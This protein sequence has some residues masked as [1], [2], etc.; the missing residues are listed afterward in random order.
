MDDKQKTEACV[1]KACDLLRAELALARERERESEERF[2]TLL[3]QTIDG[4][5]RRDLKIDR[6]D[7]LSPA[8]EKM[9]GF[10]A[11]EFGRLSRAELALLVHPDDRGVIER[12]V[13]ELEGSRG[14]GEVNGLFE[15]RLRR[16]DGVYRWLSDSGVMVFGPD[17]EPRY[18]A[19]VARDITESKE[20]EA[21]RIVSLRQTEEA[22]V[23]LRES[24]ERL[25]F[26]GDNLPG[27]LLYQFDC[28]VGG[29]ERQF[30]YISR[31]VEKIHGMSVAEAMASPF[32][33]Y[34]QLHEEDC[35]SFAEME[36]SAIEN[37][38]MIRAETRIILPSG[39]TKWI[40]ITSVPR[41]ASNGHVIWDGFEIDL[42]DRKRL[43]DEL[44][45][46]SQELETAVADRTERLRRLASELALAE[47]RERRHLSDFLHDDLQQVLVAAMYGAE[48]VL[49]D[50]PEGAG[51]ERA[52]KLLG[53]VMEAVG[54]VRSFSSGLT[55][56][57]LYVV[58]LVSALRELAEQMQAR[59]GLRVDF[60]VGDMPDIADEAVRLQLFLAV[61]ELLF[62]ATKHSGVDAVS[63]LGRYSDGR[64]ELMVSDAGKGFD[65]V[66]VLG[67]S[68]GRGY[69]LFSVRERIGDLG[70][71][72][73]VE[74]SPGG[75]TRVTIAMPVQGV[76][77]MEP[78][79]VRRTV[80]PGLGGGEDGKKRAR[81]LV[82]DDHDLV[83]DGVVNVLS[84]DRHLE[85]VGEAKNGREAVELART[86]RPDVIVMDIRM[87]EM[88][89]IEATRLILSELPGVIVVGITAFSDQGFRSAMLD[90]GAADLLDK[91]D[92]GERLRDKIAEC[93]A[94][95]SGSS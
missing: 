42:T 51:E 35:R 65:P 85:V 86:L 7:Y 17:G 75:G 70:G 2:R 56:P 69:G 8:F 25:R 59:Y 79:T 45:R 84:L 89:G 14:G 18:Y 83:R 38:S 55:T 41:R 30:T 24:E 23:R 26:L 78:R 57:L 6:Y 22:T 47:Q 12:R 76:P 63:L 94:G 28:G 60:D 54:K 20:A 3:G 67:G 58:G 64:V 93:L 53:Y 39:E 74:S 87:P 10:T 29:Q 34:S 5:Y 73:Q 68:P 19:G 36:K 48:S 66:A 62:N 92:A 43:E 81:V 37:M 4:V 33:I 49:A 44:R 80:P 82:A 88:D 32:A 16:K 13:R 11:E 9:T 72:M 46:H 90:A 50:M 61:R 71:A 21:E 77:A 27:V 95:R 1:C 40:L 31:G 52:R 15:Y 91:A